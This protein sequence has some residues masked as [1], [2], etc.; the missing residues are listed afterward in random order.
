M[1]VSGAFCTFHSACACC[2]QAVAVLTQLARARPG[3][4]LSAGDCHAL[5]LTQGL[6]H[7][8][9]HSLF[10]SFRFALQRRPV[11]SE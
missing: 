8:T 10:F 9:A 1:L 2:R 11:S 7:G 4:R 5:A 3:T 6:A